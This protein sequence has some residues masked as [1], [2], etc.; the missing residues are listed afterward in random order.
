[1]CNI[2]HSGAV[3]Q[4]RSRL[5]NV[6]IQYVLNAQVYAHQWIYSSVMA[7]P[8]FM[9]LGWWKHSSIP[10]ALYIY[11]LAW[12]IYYKMYIATQTLRR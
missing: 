10:L 2:E 12:N 6:M 1:M 8:R 3:V 9:G 4:V 11:I 5:S 7:A